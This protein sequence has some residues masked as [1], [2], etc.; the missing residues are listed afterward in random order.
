MSTI[1]ISNSFDQRILAVAGDIPLDENDQPIMTPAKWGKRWLAKRLI[2][3]VEKAE[4]RKDL[5]A[6]V[7]V[8]TGDDDIT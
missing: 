6:Y 4:A 2:A 7:Q 1:H 8:P 3:V 5:R